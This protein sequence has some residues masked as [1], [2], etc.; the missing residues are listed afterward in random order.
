MFY[1]H[2]QVD[3]HKVSMVLTLCFLIIGKL[4]VPS[5]FILSF[6]A[7]SANDRQLSCHNE[8]PLH[9]I[10]ASRVIRC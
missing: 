2:S 10:R 9:Q 7:S 4:Y 5:H 8:Y 3:R 1:T 6:P